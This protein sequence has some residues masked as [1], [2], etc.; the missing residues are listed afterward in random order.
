MADTT[1]EEK[2]FTIKVDMKELEKYQD[3]LNEVL[4]T[5][6]D[7]ISKL[8]LLNAAT[9]S[10]HKALASLNKEDENYDERLDEIT[11]GI[12]GLTVEKQKLQQVL[13]NEEK[14]QRST[15]GTYEQLNAIVNKLSMAWRKM[16]T[17]QQKA[18]KD[19]PKEINALR[20]QLKQ[21]DAAMGNFQRNVGNYSSAWNGLQV[22]MQMV[23]R[24]L[25]SLTMGANQFF[26]AIS[27]NLPM[28]A[29]EI[30]KAAEANAKLKAEGKATTPVFQ[31]LLSSLLS[32]QTALVVGITL[33]SAY[34]K[35]VVAFVKELFKGKEAIDYLAQS[36]GDMSGKIITERAQLTQMFSALRNAK[37]GTAEYAIARQNILDK[38]GS[39]L[40]SQR[41][42]IRNL[43]DIDGAYKS[44]M[45]T[46]TA[47]SIMEASMNQ[48]TE[49]AKNTNSE[50]AESIAE[51]REIFDKW[52]PEKGYTLEQINDLFGEYI[53]GITS[54]EPKLRKR[55]EEIAELFGYM[56]Y[57]PK[58]G[59]DDFEYV[60]LNR[61]DNGGAVT[62][63]SVTKLQNALAE[64]NK[65]AE[66]VTASTQVMA[67]AFGV[68]TKAV[69][70]LEEKTTSTGNAMKS[71][72]A[73]AQ[74]LLAWTQKQSVADDSQASKLT[75]LRLE[76]ER[77]RKEALDAGLDVTELERVYKE[78]V[79]TIFEDTLTVPM[80]IKVDASINLGSVN[81]Q[82]PE[83]VS[84]ALKSLIDDTKFPTAGKRDG[85]GGSK[86]E[87]N[88][89]GVTKEQQQF[90]NSVVSSYQQLYSTIEQMNKESIQRRLQDELDAL[91]RET[92]SKK[93]ALK[94]QQE[95]G[96]ISQKN[97]E[98]K[99]A[100][101]DKDA[102]TKQAELKKAA[103]EKQKKWD[104]T[105]AII[106]GAL[107]ITNI[108]A[109]NAGNPIL[110]GILTAISAANTAAQVAMISSQKYAR[111]GL[112]R[113]KSHA[114]GGIKGY[115]QGNPIELEGDEVVINKRS[116]RLFR[117]ELSAI[118]SYKGY[119]NPLPNAGA[120][121]FK[122]DMK[123][124]RGGVLAGYNFAPAPLPM[125]AAQA[126][127]A[128]NE[129]RNKGLMEA[130]G[131]MMDAKIYSIRATVLYDDI[132]SIG[133]EK[134]INVSR[135]TL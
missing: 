70:N 76:Y 123:F 94:A 108:W 79:Q 30:K 131:A 82:N 78:R 112:L 80:S 103:Y 55:A 130:I 54:N 111:G 7:N 44:L 99:L 1:N 97:Y 115:V 87:R 101:I 134:R 41:D 38:Y 9:E 129:Q 36:L 73:V 122:R 102:A 96:T 33:L 65:Q 117:N 40:Q 74:R 124:A 26:L 13:K 56:K 67:R 39:Y 71:T 93:L 119:G 4:G 118:N 27:N 46:M 88:G 15:A 125:S 19:L 5:Y 29:D 84:E 85:Q 45:D 22:Q 34:G 51:I 64:Y 32:W 28:L 60:E 8:N 59:T 11:A 61:L 120:P 66:S 42:E 52:L 3:V 77:L 23:A 12:R 90:F 107:A 37:E 57:V 89:L 113:G 20:D 62:N 68:T 132:D 49:V 95:N 31:Q 83:E 35:E 128:Q 48:L 69:A 81:I 63:S 106:N 50:V 91:D 105:T 18:F 24:E 58:L 98:R 14:L 6:D 92:D 135:A 43:K 127:T 21:A 110:A 100:Q 10:Y 133:N 109:Q 2:I 75:A 116:A 25:P 121:R 17:E 47:K 126:T 104:I 114:E 86:G 53:V 72:D 16:T